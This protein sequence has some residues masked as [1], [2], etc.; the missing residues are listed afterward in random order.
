VKLNYEICENRK[1]KEKI[2]QL[3]NHLEKE[4]NVL[5][6]WGCGKQAKI[7]FNEIAKRDC[8]Q[9]K[10]GI[11]HPPPF[12][13]HYSTMLDSVRRSEESFRLDEIHGTVETKP[14]VFKETVDISSSDAEGCSTDEVE[15]E[16]VPISNGCNVTKVENIPLEN[17]ILTNESNAKKIEKPKQKFLD[18][19]DTIIFGDPSDIITRKYKRD[20]SVTVAT[21]SQVAATVV[22]P[23]TIPVMVSVPPES[24]SSMLNVKEVETTDVPPKVVPVMVSAPPKPENSKLNVNAEPFVASSATTPTPDSIKPP[25]VQIRTCYVC[26]TKGH[27]VVYCPL[28]KKEKDVAKQQGK[29]VV[30][31]SQSTPPVIPT[32]GKSLKVGSVEIL[33]ENGNFL[34]N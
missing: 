10:N 33:N 15:V 4:Q 25:R 19:K 9:K 26:H 18:P 22:P 24:E 31:D 3:D 8:A 5:K 2:A 11:G 34:Q 13:H 7:H 27:I 17:Y 20:P 28:T 32:G 29:R 16:D 23:K 21:Y 30:V 14:S 1:N 12:L 6:A